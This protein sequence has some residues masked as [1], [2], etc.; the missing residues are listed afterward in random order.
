MHA[1]GAACYAACA[2]RMGGRCA[3]GLRPTRAAPTKMCKQRSPGRARGMCATGAQPPPQRACEMHAPTPG[4]HPTI[5]VWPEREACTKCERWQATVC[6][7][8]ARWWHGRAPDSDQFHKGIGTS[9]VEQLRPPIRSTTRISI[10]SLVCIRKPTKVSRTESPRRD[11]QNI[12][13]SFGLTIFVTPKTHFRTY[14][15]DH[16]K[17]SSNIAP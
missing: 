5:Y 7:A 15:S 6:A 2:H 1:R 12:F 14:P 11:G 8:A 16:G 17:S 4:I 10:P 3:L 13:H 9:T